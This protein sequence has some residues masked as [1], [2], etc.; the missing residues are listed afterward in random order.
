MRYLL[1][2]FFVGFC[3]FA[4]GIASQ[5]FY[6]WVDEK[7]QIH[8]TDNPNS[9]PEKYRDK[10]KKRGFRPASKPLPASPAKPQTE[11]SQPASSPQ[12]IV[13][14]FTH[15]NGHIIVEGTVNGRATVK[16][17][18][19]TL[20]EATMIPSNLALQL[21]M[22]F[23]TLPST[24]DISSL[25][26]G[27]TYIIGGGTYYPPFVQID[28]IRVGGAELRSLDATIATIEEEDLFG[29]KGRLG[30]DFLS[31][32][33]VD[34]NRE[35]NQLTLERLP[36]PY[37]GYPAEWWQG[38]Y[39]FYYRLKRTYEERRE[40]SYVRMTPKMTQRC[41]E[42]WRAVAAGRV[43]RWRDERRNMDEM[44]GFP[45]ECG[46]EDGLRT[47]EKKLDNLE[48]RASQANLPRKFR[49]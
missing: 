45:Q 44:M 17:I 29:G 26:R 34:I 9:I 14:P 38:R 11:T 31:V 7:G 36:S 40:R 20:A 24:T 19:D 28:S 6:R 13:V 2:V 30:A 21:G 15:D 25:G 41:K 47:I 42:A 23:L 10:V 35:K 32:F 33:H 1:G 4:T 37:G 3:L 39:R 27:V 48:R 18:V 43:Y 49:Q 5:Q 22:S 8:L 12:R 16:F 46:I